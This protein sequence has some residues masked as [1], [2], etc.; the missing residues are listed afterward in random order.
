MDPLLELTLFPLDRLEEF[1]AGSGL[2]WPDEFI[3]LLERDHAK[4]VELL[5]DV[6]RRGFQTPILADASEMRVWDG[7][8]RLFVAR[9]LGE[10][11]PVTWAD[12][13]RGADRRG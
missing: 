1:E 6:A 5:T 3:D 13:L 2:S 10:A 4:L 7:H 12:K 9:L 8:H 11:P